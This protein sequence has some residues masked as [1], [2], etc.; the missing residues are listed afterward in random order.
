M[1]EL[2]EFCDLESDDAR[3]SATISGRSHWKRSSVR[4]RKEGEA[5]GCQCAGGLCCSERCGQTHQRHDLMTTA[6][7]CLLRLVGGWREEMQGRFTSAL[8]VQFRLRSRAGTIE[9]AVFRS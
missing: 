8:S 1:S 6:G 3:Q 7:G 9:V 4:I 2:A 5:E